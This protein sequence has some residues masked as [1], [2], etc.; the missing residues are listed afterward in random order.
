MGIIPM[1]PPIAAS[2]EVWAKRSL[3]CL[4]HSETVDYL[5]G[6][7]YNRLRSKKEKISEKRKDYA[8]T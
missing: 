5:I 2:E 7:G 1:A 3:K 4:K 8:D 6:D